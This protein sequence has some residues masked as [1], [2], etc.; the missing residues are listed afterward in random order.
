ML[1]LGKTIFNGVPR[2]AIALKEGVPA[3][4][5]QDIQQY[6]LDVVELRIDQYA[7][8][9]AAYVLAQIQPFKNFS[10]IATIRTEKEGG[11]WK[12]SEEKRL[13]LFKTILPQVDAIDIELSATSIIKEVIQAARAHQKLVLVSYHNFDK[14]PATDKLASVLAEAKSLGA[15]VVK[16]ATLATSRA[17]VQTLAGFTLA[18]KEK[19][20]ITIAMGPEGV[21]SRVLFPALGSL[22]TYTFLDKPVAPGQLDYR[23][24][25]DLLRLLYP[26]HPAR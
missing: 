3:Q 14:T 2:V 25:V 9:D 21:V 18:N 26:N 11:A 13:E 15:D 20:I 17:D 8:F 24:T 1:K 16:I 5:L 12:G 19:N 4:T 23:Q 7:S 10:S 22:L 6:G